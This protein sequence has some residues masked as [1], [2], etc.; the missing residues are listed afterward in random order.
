MREQDDI[1]LLDGVCGDAID[2]HGQRSSLSVVQ[3][4][5]GCGGVADVMKEDSIKVSKVL[6]DDGWSKKLGG[7]SWWS[8]LLSVAMYSIGGGVANGR[9]EDDIMV[10]MV[11]A[12]DSI[13]GSVAWMWMIK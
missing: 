9:E 3:M 7:Q 12:T 8:M 6:C 5:R 10:V 4:C 2:W 13:G 11:G 1:G